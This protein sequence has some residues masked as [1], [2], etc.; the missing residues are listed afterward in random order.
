MDKQGRLARTQ[1]CEDLIPSSSNANSDADNSEGEFKPP[2]S[3]APAVLQSITGRFK[4]Q[5]RPS[6]N[7]DILQNISISQAEAEAGRTKRQFG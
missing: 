7:Y 6:L 4:R 2:A 3:T 5:R 1:E